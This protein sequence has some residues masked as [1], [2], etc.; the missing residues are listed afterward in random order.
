MA[1]RLAPVAEVPAGALAGQDLEPQVDNGRVAGRDDDEAA[2]RPEHPLDLPT[3][4]VQVGD[5][6]DGIDV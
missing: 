2:A 5:E 4:A 3:G 6:L 1:D